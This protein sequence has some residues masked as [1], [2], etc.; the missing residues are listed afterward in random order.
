MTFLFFSHLFSISGT[1][2][3]HRVK[4]ARGWVGV[5]TGG[6]T[7]GEAGP[8]HTHYPPSATERS[9]KQN[10]TRQEKCRLH[11]HSPKI[12]VWEKKHHHHPIKETSKTTTTT[13]TTSATSLIIKNCLWTKI[14]FLSQPPVPP[15]NQTKIIASK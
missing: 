1:Y 8:R 9:S 11:L 2:M 15:S 4:R 10:R 7:R 14:D 3:Q 12:Y 5:C 6:R 13:T